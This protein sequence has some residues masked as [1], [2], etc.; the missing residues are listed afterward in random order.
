MYLKIIEIEEKKLFSIF[1]SVKSP[2]S[3][4]VNVR[5]LDSLDFVNFPEFRT[6]RDVR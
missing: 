4:K 1:D 2:V 5:F 3:R 6:R